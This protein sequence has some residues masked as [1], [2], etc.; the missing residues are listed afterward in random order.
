MTGELLRNPASTWADQARTS[1]AG[2]RTGTLRTR[3]CRTPSTETLVS[4]EVADDGRVRVL[5]SGSSP[6]VPAL[7][8]C[9]VATLTVP[10]PGSRV[11][12]LTGSFTMDRPDESGVRSYTPTLLSVRLVEPGRDDVVVPV[13]AFW[14]SE[15]DTFG[16][17]AAAVLRHLAAVHGE[18]LLA[19][20]R[21][22]GYDAASVVP[23]V[24]DRDG[25]ELA[26]LTLEGVDRWRVP[27]E[28]CVS[29]AGADLRTVRLPVEC[30]CPDRV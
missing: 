11:V 19:G 10:G 28:G 24:V 23:L 9:R 3:S 5:L 26:V 20:A 16:H 2:A 29:A 1:V 22:Q 30:T 14:R 6:A 21:A 15:P 4:V 25:V 8:A 17:Q 27:F 18:D 12:R 7:A 13:D